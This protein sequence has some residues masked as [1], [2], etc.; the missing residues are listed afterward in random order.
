MSAKRRDRTESPRARIRIYP[1]DPAAPGGLVDAS[2]PSPIRGEPPFRI[3]GQRYEPAP[4]A[5]GTLAFDYWQGEAALERAIGVWEDL[6]DRDFSTWHS[7]LPLRVKLR[8]G[9]DLNAFYDRASLQFFYDVD[10]V[11][12]RKV[13]AAE[14]LDVVTHETGHAILDVFQP[15]Y[16]SSVDL[17]TAA[18]HEAFGDCSALITTLT[19]PTVRSAFLT[20][21]GAPQRTR[22][23]NLVSRLA[24]ALGRALYDN[25]GPGAVGDPTCIRDANNTLRYSS[26]EGLPTSSRDGGSLTSE[27]HSFSR[28]FTGAFYD[29]LIWLLAR[30]LREDPS[31]E[32]VERAR[33]LAGKLL[34]RSIETL[35]PGVARYRAVALG[36]RTIDQTE[37]D[38]TASEGIE[39]SF[40][41]HGIKLGKIETRSGR[42]MI[43]APHHALRHLDPDRPGGAG[44]LR[45]ALRIPPGAPL[46]RTALPARKGAGAREQFIHRDFVVVRHRSLGKLSGV[47]VRVPCGCTVVRGPSGE[48]ER[49]ALAPHPHP[50]AAELLPHLRRWVAMDA[51]QAKGAGSSSSRVLYRERK[52]FRVTSAGILERAYFD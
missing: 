27:P 41:R 38:G 46:R 21:A 26:P 15:S 14:S 4:Y 48:V 18:F 29:L 52:P 44:A 36:M 2:A 6:F 8:A 9:R 3:E 16:W 42:T 32:G 23:S 1:N 40:E 12:G 30:E 17:E 7:G 5:P 50:T 39:K 10:R 31:E 19:E 22:T 37:G 45:A 35:P 34:A 43:G 24:E 47:A 13:Y 25:F 51:I 20:A 11:T 33:R 28:V 49:M